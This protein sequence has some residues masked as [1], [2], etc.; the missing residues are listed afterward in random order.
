MESLVRIYANFSGRPFLFL[1]HVL[2]H[3][4]FGTLGMS[5]FFWDNS[6]MS[7]ACLM[8][9]WVSTADKIDLPPEAKIGFICVRRSDAAGVEADTFMKC[10]AAETP[11]LAVF[12]VS[13]ALGAHI[14]LA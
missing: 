3:R 1:S 5:A 6:T 8:W 11:D 2:I 9:F 12:N 7:V 14:C 10:S 4:V 13:S